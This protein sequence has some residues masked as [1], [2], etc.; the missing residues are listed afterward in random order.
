MM[1]EI[2]EALPP[3]KDDMFDVHN[4]D[5]ENTG[6]TDDHDEIHG[7][8]HTRVNEEVRD[9]LTINMELKSIMNESV[10]EPI[11]FFPIEEEMP[12]KEVEEFDSCSF[13]NG[14]KA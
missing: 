13:D 10:K 11:H 4:S 8:S 12:T 6:I 1:Q 2:P 14:N 5:Y 3:R 7:E 9:E